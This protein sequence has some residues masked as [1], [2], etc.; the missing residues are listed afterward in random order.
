VDA[1][2]APTLSASTRRISSQRPFENRVVGAPDA[3]A[4]AS[5]R[6]LTPAPVGRHE[7]PNL[8][9]KKTPGTPS[10]SVGS[11]QEGLKSM[12]TNTFS[13]TWH[14]I[15]F[16]GFQAGGGLPQKRW[17]RRASYEIAGVQG[18]S[19]KRDRHQLDEHLNRKP[20][21]E[22]HRPGATLR[23]A[24]RKQLKSAAISFRSD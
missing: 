11:R 2:G 22:Q 14:A 21:D 5:A 3:G 6:D 19:D 4:G 15:W 20:I 8:F 24:A 1:R 12:T 18:S 9:T 7:C 17:A 16:G 23:I 13:A 10:G